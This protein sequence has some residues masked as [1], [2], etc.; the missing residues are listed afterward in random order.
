M[1]SGFRKPMWPILIALMLT[2]GAFGAVTLTKETVLTDRALYFTDAF[3]SSLI[4]VHVDCMDVVNDYIYVVWYEGGMEN[5]ILHLSRQSTS[6]P[7]M[8]EESEEYYR[9]APCFRH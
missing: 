8:A 5:R 2:A 4:S 9:H 7:F 3:F 1:H 6:P